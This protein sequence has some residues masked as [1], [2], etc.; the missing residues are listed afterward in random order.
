MVILAQEKRTPERDRYHK[1]RFTRR[2]EAKADINGETGY[3]VTGSSGERRL[4]WNQD[5]MAVI[6]SST[7]L[8][9]DDLIKVA[10]SVR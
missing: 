4:F 3:F 10:R 6:I 5:E 9:D 7:F 8:S 2:A 1:D